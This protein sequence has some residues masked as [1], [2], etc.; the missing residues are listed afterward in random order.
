LFFFVHLFPFVLRIFYFCVLSCIPL[1]LDTNTF[2]LLQFCLNGALF[3]A[4][5][6]NLPFSDWSCTFLRP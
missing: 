5:F 3:L 2:L 4:P 6:P 1:L